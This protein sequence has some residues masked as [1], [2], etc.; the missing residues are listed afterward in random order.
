MSDSD[1]KV[2]LELLK[3]VEEQIKDLNKTMKERHEEFILLKSTVDSFFKRVDEQAIIIKDIKKELEG[4]VTLKTLK[5]WI[6]GLASILTSLG[7]IGGFL[8]K[9]M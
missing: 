3:R 2:A 9:L 6:I 5:G 1:I 7:I 8:I 4:N